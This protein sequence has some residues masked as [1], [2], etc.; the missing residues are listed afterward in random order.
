MTIKEVIVSTFNA[1][2]NADVAITVKGKNSET[3]V[4]LSKDGK[5]TLNVKMNDIEDVKQVD[6]KNDA[7]NV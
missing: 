5:H 3:N 1:L 7:E 4:G 2:K 6:E